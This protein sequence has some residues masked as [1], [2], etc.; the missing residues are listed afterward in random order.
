MCGSHSPLASSALNNSD[1]RVDSELLIHSASVVTDK[2]ENHT[3]KVTAVDCLPNAGKL[4]R[5]K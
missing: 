3:G 1:E 2:A 5:R 4:L